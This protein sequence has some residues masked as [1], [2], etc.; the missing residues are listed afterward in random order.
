MLGFDRFSR[1][2]QTAVPE[3]VAGS[4]KPHQNI[5]DVCRS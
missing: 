3:L 1:H 2:A 5:D 4:W